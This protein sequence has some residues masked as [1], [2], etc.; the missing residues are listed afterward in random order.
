MNEKIRV[1][2]S[3]EI[4]NLTSDIDLFFIGNKLNSYAKNIMPFININDLNDW[5]ILISVILRPTNGIGVYKRV[6]R[7]PSDKEFEISISIT[8]PDDKQVA[9]GSSRVKDGF[10]LPMDEGKFHFLNPNFDEYNC[11]KD[12][13]LS[14]A[15]SAIELAFQCGFTCNG[16]KIKYQKMN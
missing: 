7:Y 4:P 13:I 6:K 5:S 11:L 15:K 2:M 16:K 8:I 3:C 14:S 12:Y 9:Y 1:L 10:Y